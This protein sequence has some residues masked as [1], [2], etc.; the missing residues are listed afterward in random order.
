MTDE[1]TILIIEIEPGPVDFSPPLPGQ[2]LST[3]TAESLPSGTRVILCLDGGH[4]NAL[5]YP[6]TFHGMKRAIG[7]DEDPRRRAYVILDE[8]V[9]GQGWWF[10]PAWKL[11]MAEVE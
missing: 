9:G 6:G 11:K 4:G 10:G 2:M 8:P 3:L 7:D 5:E 1:P